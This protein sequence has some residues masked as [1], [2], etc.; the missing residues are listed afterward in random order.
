M[1]M[2]FPPN[3][4]SGARRTAAPYAR[5]PAPSKPAI[6]GRK[7]R[8]AAALE[9]ALLAPHPDDPVQSAHP[10]F[11]HLR[12][13]RQRW[14][15]KLAAIKA[16]R[17]APAAEATAAAPV[18]VPQAQDEEAY[19]DCA[20]EEQR[21]EN[22][23]DDVFLDASSCADDEDDED[24]G[25]EGINSASNTTKPSSPFEAAFVDACAIAARSYAVKG[26]APPAPSR[27]SSASSRA[28]PLS[29]PC[30]AALASAR[31]L[32][33]PTPCRPGSAK[34]DLGRTGGTYALVPDSGRVAETQDEDGNDDAAAGEPLAARDPWA[35]S[36]GGSSCGPVALAS[37]LLH[38][39]AADVE[40]AGELA[41]AVA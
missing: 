29:R 26:D 35:T 28:R 20:K 41:A 34:M 6:N 25:N 8:A 14:A 38:G 17:V 23:V 37:F 32:A 36:G 19:Y 33:S 3:Q 22:D 18:V 1:M 21:A 2:A 12:A 40:E 27:P 4:R 16:A 10:R 7:T 9:R 30:S 31:A 15:P 13:L 24:D 5:V 11:C 39:A